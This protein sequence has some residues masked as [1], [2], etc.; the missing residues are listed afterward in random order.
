M[1][2]VTTHTA[3]G[4]LSGLKVLEL[5]QLIAG[6]FAAKTLADFGAE[7]IKIEPPGTGDPLRKW[8]L[9]KDGTSVWWQVQSRNKRSLALDLRDPEGQAIVRRLAGEADVLIENFRPGA[10]EGWGLAPDD[11][12]GLNPRLI[13]LR[14][15]GYGQTGPYRDRPGFGVVAEA[16]GGLRHLT[17]EPGRVPVRVGV[18]IGDTLAALHGVIGIL[19]ALQ[20]RH[21]SGR[22]QVIDVALYEAVFN[23]ME[24]LLPEYSAFGAVREAAGSALPGIAPT[25][26]YLC[27]DGGYALIAGNGD[28]IFRRLMTLIGR[29]D[30]GGDPAL[31]DNAGRVAR[32]AELDA[33][34]GAWT[35]QRPVDEVLAALA[36]ASV[37]AGRIYTVADIAADP[38][39][40]ARG[41]LQELRMDDG[42]TLAV[43]GIVPKLSLTPGSHRRNAPALGQDS[44]AVLREMGLTP[45][46][47]RTL[48]ERGIVNGA[49]A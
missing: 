9:L 16:M 21:A 43:P 32:V 30:L 29:E 24:S 48:K 5:G 19:L 49:S 25:N 3:P 42:S 35:A 40:R 8:R 13:V 31:A 38:H 14:I 41:M 15:S 20:H 6:P 44:D 11:L 46:Q 2:T 28:S 34:I 12:L 7:V 18:S 23:C 4:A 1:D 17:A 47:I 27:R 39:Y 37:P 45:Q 10:M 26:A 33:A 36:K 22:G